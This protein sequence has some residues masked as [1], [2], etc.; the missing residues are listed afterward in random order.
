[1]AEEVVIRDESLLRHF[2]FCDPDERQRLYIHGRCI[3]G[4]SKE[5]IFVGATVHCQ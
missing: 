2:I 4:K 3:Q 5:K 1:M